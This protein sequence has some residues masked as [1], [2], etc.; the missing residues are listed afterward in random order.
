MEQVAVADRSGTLPFMTEPTGR[1][2]G[3]GLEGGEQITVEVRHVD[4]VL[5]SVL[6]REPVIDLLKLDTEGAEAATVRAIAPD[7]L[8][9][10]RRI[11]C[12]DAEDEIDIP[13]W[14]R[15]FSCLTTTLTNPVAPVPPAPRSS[16]GG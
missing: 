16:P 13:G 6:E 14:R 12:E 15:R 7:L 3:L 9:R 5:R 8:A 2:G 10:I 1:Y 11:V 4:D